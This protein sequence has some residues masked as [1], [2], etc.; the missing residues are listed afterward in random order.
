MYTWLAN[1]LATSDAGV[2][3]WAC[4]CLCLCLGPFP[5]GIP[6]LQK[7]RGPHLASGKWGIYITMRAI[8][9]THCSLASEALAIFCYEQ[10]IFTF[11][12]CNLYLYKQVIRFLSKRAGNYIPGKHTKNKIRRK[13]MFPHTPACSWILQCNFLNVVCQIMELQ[14]SSQ[15]AVPA[16]KICS[17]QSRTIQIIQKNPMRFLWGY[18][19][20]F[21]GT[22][23]M[24]PGAILF[25][26][27]NTAICL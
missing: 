2:G 3:I 22:V 16:Q 17:S 15:K 4:T 18:D 20:N 21:L 5:S 12:T 26:E 8:S 10:H 9:F 1:K 25:I 24:E 13:I 14:P 23:F 7:S 19:F 6:C 11:S 27:R